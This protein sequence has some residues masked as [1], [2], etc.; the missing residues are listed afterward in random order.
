MKIKQIKYK[1]KNHI[2][3]I[4]ECE[5]CGATRTFI[6]YDNENYYKYYKNALPSFK[7][8]KCGKER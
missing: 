5:H 7:C 8:A 3:G 6:G 2:Y 1:I 4:L